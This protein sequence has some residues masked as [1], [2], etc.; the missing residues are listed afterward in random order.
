MCQMS[1]V[2]E[3][4]GGEELL[5]EG[6]TRLEVEEGLIRVST[7]FEAPV[8]VSGAVLREIDFLGGRVILTPRQS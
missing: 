3:K 6:A 2:M 4:E 8:E 7:F 1:V 5:V